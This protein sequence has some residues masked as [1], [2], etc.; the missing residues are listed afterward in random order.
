MKYALTS[1]LPKADPSWTVAIIYSSW[2]PELVGPMVEDAKRTLIRAGISEK[3]ISFYEAPGSFEIPLIGAAIADEK[4]TDALIAL[5]IIVKGETHHAD[6]IAEQTVRGIMEVQ[7]C[8]TL[9][10]AFEVLYVDALDLAKARRD[11]GMTAAV[12][13]LHSLREL[14]RIAE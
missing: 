6:L 4:R 13:T 9:P 8:Y 14:Q 2:Y 1:P 12:T 10:F 7:L 5:G 11:T 3:N